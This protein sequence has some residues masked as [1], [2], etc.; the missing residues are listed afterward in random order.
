MP[1]RGPQRPQTS[2]R[3]AIYAGVR[4]YT[5]IRPPDCHLRAAAGNTRNRLRTK[6]ASLR[7]GSFECRSASHYI[8]QSNEAD[9]LREIKAFLGGLQ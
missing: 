3:Q 8:F 4:E 2:I 1:Q 6:L 5:D 7:P 9:V